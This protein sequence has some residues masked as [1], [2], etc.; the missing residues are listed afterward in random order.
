MREDDIKADLAKC[1]VDKDYSLLLNQIPQITILY[2]FM[3]LVLINVSASP[4]E[5]A[6]TTSYSIRL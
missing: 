1:D 6:S 3:G 2:F 4:P 5:V